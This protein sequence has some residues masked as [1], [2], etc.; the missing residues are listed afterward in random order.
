VITVSPY[1]RCS[2]YSKSAEEEDDPGML[3]KRK[4]DLCHLEKE[5]WTTG[6]RYSWRKMVE[7]AAHDGQ[8]VCGL[9]L[10]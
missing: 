8:V 4:K 6:F 3:G 5:T 9:C 1:K 10:H 2:G 7:A